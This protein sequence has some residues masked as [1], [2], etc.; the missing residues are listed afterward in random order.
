MTTR[1]DDNWIQTYTGRQFWP[2]DPRC[3]DIDI[4]DIAHALAL[5]C[6]YTGH[7][8]LFYSIAQHSVI[9]SMI[10]PP[11]DMLAAL[12]HDASEA[13]LADVARPV[14]RA[15][16]DFLSAEERLE[17]V[18]AERFGLPHPMPDAVKR[19]DLILLRT[20]RRDLMGPPPRPW[21]T[22]EQIKPMKEKIIPWDWEWSKTRFLERYD[23]FTRQR[24]Y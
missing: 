24:A 2:L 12:M 8:R 3:E 11:A 19:A 1:R 13:Y 16:P 21:R 15:L 6:R 7:C 22:D 14:K 9:A 23:E 5:K 17:R 18:L 20:E 4:F 10:V